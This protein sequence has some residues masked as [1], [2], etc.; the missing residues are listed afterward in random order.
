VRRKNKELKKGT[1]GRIAGGEKRDP[2][3]KGESAKGNGIK[4]WEDILGK[5]RANDGSSWYGGETTK[6]ARSEGEG[7]A[8]AGDTKGVDVGWK[9][10]R[11]Q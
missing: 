10:V 3:S 4:G 6:P 9:K 8:T 2:G 7:R 11:H 5:G 1:C